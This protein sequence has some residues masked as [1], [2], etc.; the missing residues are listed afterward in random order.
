MSC[1]LAGT[2][3]PSKKI[4][5]SKVGGRSPGHGV[6]VVPAGVATAWAWATAVAAPAVGAG[7]SDLP[8]LTRVTPSTLRRRDISVATSS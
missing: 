2:S 8:R 1:T 4:T 3:L 5:S 7:L 6:A